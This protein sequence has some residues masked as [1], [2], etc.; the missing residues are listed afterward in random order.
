MLTSRNSPSAASVSDSPWTTP[1]S[2]DTNDRS[3]AKVPSAGVWGTGR[4]SRSAGNRHLLVPGKRR[5]NVRQTRARVATRDAMQMVA[6]EREDGER[7][8]G[9]EA[10][11]RV[12]VAEDEPVKRNL[13]G[14]TAQDGV[15][16]RGGRVAGR[17]CL[18]DLELPERTEI[19]RAPTAKALVAAR[20]AGEVERP[21]RRVTAVEGKD[22]QP[23]LCRLERLAVPLPKPRQLVGRRSAD[24]EI[25][26]ALDP[27]GPLDVD[28]AEA[29]EPRSVETG[30]TQADR[31]D[32]AGRDLSCRVEK[33]FR[34]WSERGEQLRDPRAGA[35]HGVGERRPLEE[36]AL[37]GELRERVLD[38]GTG[39]LAE[40]SDNLVHRPRAVEERQQCG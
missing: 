13:G 5:R 34:A 29:K 2:G 3:R 10:G 14:E 37:G 22:L 19:G 23:R 27:A 7:L 17:H 26:A 36:Q 12:V 21:Y 38:G 32:R 11:R 31:A 1:A 25:D 33:R 39:G 4:S 18:E 9:V 28:P 40:H 16:P 15:E 30:R 8:E 35:R 6:R 24:D 20:V